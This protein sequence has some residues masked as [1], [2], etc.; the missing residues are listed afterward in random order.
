MGQQRFNFDKRHTQW[1]AQRCLD[2]PDRGWAE[3][4]KRNQRNLGRRSKGQEHLLA[5]RRRGVHWNHRPLRGSASGQNTDRR[6]D[7]RIGEQQT[8]GTDCSYFGTERNHT[9]HRITG[10]HNRFEC[11]I[12]FALLAKR[13]GASYRDLSSRKMYCSGVRL[14]PTCN[15]AFLLHFSSFL[16]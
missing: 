3:A 5:G 12:L 9:A 7:R 15:L 2:F 16:R 11:P 4:G 1:R 14:S 13:M 10:H 8:P 6:Q